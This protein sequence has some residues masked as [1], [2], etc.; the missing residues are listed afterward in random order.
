LDK[1]QAKSKIS[2]PIEATEPP[3]PL[4]KINYIVQLIQYITPCCHPIQ[5]VKDFGSVA[6][7][8]YEWAWEINI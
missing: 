7:L 3:S 8:K 2:A 6:E 1:I 4:F 5:F